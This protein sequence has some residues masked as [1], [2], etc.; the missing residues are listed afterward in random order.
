MMGCR[1]YDESF[2][3]TE[4][5]SSV[6]E[7]M[8]W[9]A[10]NVVYMSDSVVHAEKD[11]WQMPKETY[12]RRTGDCEDKALLAMY[13]LKEMGIDS[14]LVIVQIQVQGY[15]GGYHAIVKVGNKYYDPVKFY[16][17]GSV[18]YPFK[19]L[20]FYEYNS[21]MLLAYLRVLHR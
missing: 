2:A 13:F 6:Q 7:V 10:T 5:F 19:I 20:E 21:A 12:Q 17:N 11:E 4:S 18:W 16:D 9:V 14:S 1:F 3:H 15:N 8:K